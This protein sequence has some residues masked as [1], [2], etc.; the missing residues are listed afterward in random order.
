MRF[1]PVL[2]HAVLG[3][4]F[5]LHL[6]G[7]QAQQKKPA[8]TQSPA[9]PAPIRS[10]PI[11]NVRYDLTFDSTTASRRSIEVAMSFDVTGPGAV[12][13]S[14]PSWTPGAY[15]IGNFARWVVGFTPTGS[16]SALTW[17]KLDYDTWR[18]QPGRSK[19]VTVRFDYM[20][21]SLDNAM[22]WSRP[23][24]AFF[25]GTNLF[26]YPEGRGFNFP[27]AVTLKTQE[28]WRITTSM[29]PGQAPGSFAV[30][31]FHDL[32]DTPVFIGQFDV[33]SMQV[34]GRTTRLATYPAGILTGA[35]RQRLWDD[36]GKMIPAES[37][38]F[39]ETP[40]DTYSNLLIFDPSYGG[41]SALEHSSSHLGIYNPQ[42]IGTPLLSSITAHEIFHAWN[43]KRLRPAE[44][45]PYRYDQA[46]PTPWLW[47]SEGITDYYADLALSRG[48][49]IDSTQFLTVTASKVTTVADAPPTALE[50]ASLSTWIHP[51]DGSGYIYYPKGS[52]AGLL[53][54]ILIRDGSDNARSL[55]DVMRQLYQGTY[56]KTRG[57]NGTDWWSA[58]SK[59]TGGRSFADFNKRYIDG[60]EP[61]PFDSILPLAGLKM[62]MDTV[63]D[64]RLGISTNSDSAGIVVNAVVPGGPAEAAG[65]RPGDHILAIG[66]LSVTNPDF[67]P[68]FR[69]RYSKREGAPLP[70]KVRR[71]TDTLTLNGKVV[72]AARAERRIQMDPNASDKAVRIRNGIMNGK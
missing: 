7:A 42:F 48:G 46:Q 9:T 14:L 37:A 20:A 13:L 64:P 54:D 65:V 16:D 59:A 52:L 72:L 28:G 63:R 71:G 29:R 57:F 47:V 53:I 56:K 34:S 66:D 41:G 50:D 4:F 22:A 70:I 39:Q 5:F 23:D 38:V 30:S 36:I 26:F 62:T 45:V 10:A 25:N 2:R 69:T 35:Q 31:N 33:D 58:V 27:A 15:E 49:I 12:L 8:T 32:V 51:V 19:E 6:T 24:F 11:A 40:W 67:G 18:V 60:R 68:E 43:V 61:F 55:D 3:T 17:D 21:D 44:M 1:A